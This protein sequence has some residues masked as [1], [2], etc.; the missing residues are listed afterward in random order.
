MS[1]RRQDIFA[2]RKNMSFR[3]LKPGYNRK[4]WPHDGGHH[5]VRQ[6]VFTNDKIILCTNDSFCGQRIH[7]RA[8]I[9]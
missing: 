3:N 9:S 2:G 8:G 1:M 4:K 5:E 6:E 7:R